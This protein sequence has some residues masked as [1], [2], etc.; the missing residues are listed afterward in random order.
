MSASLNDGQVT[1]VRLPE[2][3]TLDLVSQNAVLVSCGPNGVTSA[4]S[5]AYIHLRMYQSRLASCV[6]MFTG[7]YSVLQSHTLGFGRRVK[8]TVLT[9]DPSSET[10]A[11]LRTLTSDIPSPMVWLRR[12]QTIGGFRPGPP[13]ESVHV[14][15]GARVTT[16][17]SQSGL[18]ASSGVRMS[19]SILARSSFSDETWALV[20]CEASFCSMSATTSHSNVFSPI[21]VHRSLSIDMSF[22]S[23]SIKSTSLGASSMKKNVQIGKSGTFANAGNAVPFFAALARVWVMRLILRGR[24]GV[25]GG[26]CISTATPSG[27]ASSSRG[28]TIRG[29]PASIPLARP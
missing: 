13:G 29:G 26:P 24:S 2:Y 4:L 28:S 11:S 7:L 9:G 18:D 21:T 25:Y 1:I 27:A 22:F 17:T 10:H 19:A 3:T 6:R 15:L 16:V 12:T 8:L 23:V 14:A 20:T 5:T